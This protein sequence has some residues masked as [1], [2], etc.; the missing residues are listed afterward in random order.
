MCKKMLVILLGAVVMVGFSSKA[1]AEA[2][3]EFHAPTITA[4]PGAELHIPI[5]A[6]TQIGIKA[7]QLQMNFCQDED[8]MK[9]WVDSV[10]LHGDGTYITLVDTIPT[11]GA[12]QA[13]FPVFD[14]GGSPPTSPGVT[15]WN[16]GAVDFSSTG[17]DPLDNVIV[18]LVW[19][20]VD[21]GVTPPDTIELDIEPTM[22][23]PPGYSTQCLF[24]DNN[25]TGH[26]A[27][28]FDGAI[29]IPLH[30]LGIS[31]TPAPP[32]TVPEGGSVSVTVEG[33]DSDASHT[34]T[35]DADGGLA[36]F[37]SWNGPITG[38]T[39]VDGTL[40]LNP[41]FCDAGNYTVTFS[42]Y[43]QE[44]Q[45]TISVDYDIVVENTN[46]PP[47]CEGVDPGNATISSGSPFHEDITF[48]DPDITECGD[49]ALT[50]TFEMSP[51][52]ATMPSFTDNGDGTGSFDWTP[53]DA[54][55]NTYTVFF[56]GTDNSGASDTC[57]V[58]IN[59]VAGCTAGD[60]GAIPTDYAFQLKKVIGF[61]GEDV[62]YPVFLSANPAA[63][64]IG[65]YEVLIAY[66]P[67]CMSLT[68]VYEAKIDGY[69]SE[70]FEWNPIPAGVVDPW[71]AVRIVEV[72]DKANNFYTPPIPADCELPI[73]FLAFHM[74]HDW[75]PNYACD[76]KFVVND[77]GDNTL[78]NPD[79][80]TLH[81]PDYLMRVTSGG[82]DSCTV[83]T[84]F[85]GVCP[86][87]SGIAHDVTLLDGGEWAGNSAWSSHFDGVLCNDVPVTEA[88]YDTLIGYCHKGDITSGVL[89]FTTGDVNLN[90][91]PYEVSDISF[92][93]QVL[94]GYYYDGYPWGGADWQRSSMAS[95][96]NHNT[97]E[98]ETGDLVLMTAITNGFIQ[99][100]TTAPE[101]TKE[102]VDL[103][104]PGV[105]TKDGEV[106]ISTNTDI[107]GAYF[108]I[109]YEGNIG[110]P[111]LGEFAQGMTLD[112]N[113]LG[114]E[115]RVLIWSPEYHTMRKG[116]GVLFRIPGNATLTFKKVDIADAM[117]RT[118]GVN[119]NLVAFA[120]GDA[121]PNPFSG[122]TKISFAIAKNAPV[123]LKIYDISGKLVKT[124]VNANLKPGVYTYTWDGL[125]NH[126]RSV[127][128][129]VYFYRFDAK[130]Y[131]STKKLLLLR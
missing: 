55:V 67:S 116:S 125:D 87:H 101:P 88:D 22:T 103:T 49:D 6:T 83:F 59:V 4:A 91:V 75:D 57:T 112:W 93:N 10:T 21:P 78:S 109:E 98:W 51:A 61:A 128:A 110:T 114:G 126:G 20:H 129:G 19:A 79:G 108:I 14:G 31:F 97:V 65:A 52:P 92:F 37:M 40:D 107:G 94:L 71:P 117:G 2:G 122:S 104:L 121:K 80:L 41:G 58:E 25:V 35:L 5:Y 63:D 74:N 131:S 18:C 68:G 39:P 43:C 73:F 106:T 85:I 32:L 60:F 42:L 33:T 50:L 8:S 7:F 53:T 45:Q 70:Y 30:T 77:C 9:I 54:D 84:D 95:D 72:R 115:L 46:R 102:V 111:E 62:L 123:S 100:L 118:L 26:D 48:S 29:I 1:F 86:D 17:T 96:V 82:G 76:V 3:W 15:G 47:V 130:N 24:T 66:D 89:D 120:L 36:G 90:T 56:I 64:A 127:P 38:N 12:W 44:T 69:C 13:N 113:D 28:N 99:P 119:T 81:V 105:V 124:L 34:I 23:C 11:G 16:G 27:D